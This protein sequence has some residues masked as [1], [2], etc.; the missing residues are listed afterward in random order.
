MWRVSNE[1]SDLFP[2]LCRLDARPFTAHS[3]HGIRSQSA[4]PVAAKLDHEGHP[5]TAIHPACG[6]AIHQAFVV[7]PARGRAAE[8]RDW[9]FPADLPAVARPAVLA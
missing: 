8:S 2:R 4:S 9:D 5:A 6:P 1:N 3:E 7:H